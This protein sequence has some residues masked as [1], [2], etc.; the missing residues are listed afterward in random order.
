MAVNNVNHEQIVLEI[1][2]SE[3]Y[4]LKGHDQGTIGK[5]LGCSRSTVSRLLAKAIE[6][7]VV[8]VRIRNPLERVKEV[9]ERIKK[10][11]SL[12]HAVIVSGTYKDGGLLRKALGVAAA[13]L[14][15]E[16][17]E[18]N[19]L[20]GIS[21]GRTILEVVNSL[22]NVEKKLEIKVGPLFGGRGRME[23]E[24]QIN[25]L[26]REFAHHF[27]GVSGVLDAPFVVKTQKTCDLLLEEAGIKEIREDWDRLTKVFVTIGPPAADSLLLFNYAELDEKEQQRLRAE[28][29]GDICGRFIDKDGN[30][31]QTSLSQQIIGI[32]FE[33]L[34]K[35]PIR[36]GIGGGRSRVSAAKG[37][38]GRGL[39]NVL[40][41][42]EE[43]A[44]II[45]R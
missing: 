36:V 2:A 27:G 33:Q 17:I 22:A 18:R 3:L 34:S 13:E 19:E 29:V 1:K 32:T 35:V 26:C 8:E 5:M 20:I 44:G 15:S 21:S 12:E 31:C 38:L 23:A 28:A 6:N 4:F 41:T 10:E 24:Y 25:E 9:E 42:D 40:V 16:I 39:I 37:A 45:L 43:T 11:F 7:G 14:A 30:E